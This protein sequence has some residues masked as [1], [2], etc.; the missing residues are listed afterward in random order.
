MNR[1]AF[2]ST[3]LAIKAI[4]DMTR[5][6]VNLHDE[7]NIPEGSVIFAVNH[8][9][10]IETIFLPLHL[11][12][13]TGVPVWSLADASLFKGFV[14]DFISEAGAVSTRDP[15]RD[16]LMVKSLL[17]GEANWVIFPEGRMVKTKKIFEDGEFVIDAE[18]G[19]HRPHTGA[20]TLALRTEFYRERLRMMREKQPE[21]Y[22][23]LLDLFGVDE[24]KPRLDRATS[25]VPV[26][27]TYYPLRARESIISRITG[28]LIDNPSSRTLEEVM[29]E[30]SM[31]LDGVDVDVR[32]GKPIKVRPYLKNPVVAW[33]IANPEPIDFDDPINS[34]AV[35]REASRTLMQEYMT[36]IYS[37]TMVNHDHIFS[38]LIMRHE[39]D[40]IDPMDLKTR[41]FVVSDWL[42]RQ[43]GIHIHTSLEDSQSHLLTDDRYEK[44]SNIMEVAEQ[45]G[46]IRRDE[47]GWIV[48]N[49]DLLCNGGEF[50]TLRIQNPLMVMSNEVE[51]L[52][53]LTAFLDQVARE[54]AAHIRRRI[55]GL[56][57]EKGI[58]DFKKD[59]EVY[60]IEGESKPPEIGAPCLLNGDERRIGVLLIHG[61]MAAPAEVRGLAD[62][63]QSQGYWVYTPR[64]RGHGTAPE[65]LAGRG[66]LDWVVSVEEGYALLR[67]M[68]DSLFIGGFSTGAG[69]ALDLVTRIDRARTVKGVFAV[70]PPMKLQ[71]YSSRFV[72]AVDTWNTVMKRLR[73]DRARKEFIE[74]KPENPHINY[75]RNSVAGIREI[76]RLMDQLAPKLEKIE[77]PALIVQSARDP[78]VSPKGSRKVF[79]S[80]AS[81]DKEYRLFNFS[82]HG[83]L[84]HEGSEK[85]YRA[86][87]EFLEDHL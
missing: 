33:D 51:P 32:F 17:T 61:Y 40:Y 75:T 41:A 28:S 79:E 57:L 70:A 27:I 38:R 53:G 20:A 8:F 21:E 35:L 15:D 19:K 76:D 26:N 65:D 84:L 60:S 6:R 87:S 72:P 37:M 43:I 10:R 77:I 81:E 54:P 14:G 5:T 45:K 52:T 12:K 16:K 69:L 50:H 47:E 68:C 1:F 30:G 3:G 2:L 56:L 34:R 11:Q 24:T 18:E 31:L 23:R 71:D 9:T 85:V 59:Y 86:V 82:R 44:F 25:I 80:I 7:E 64:L 22:R 62:H 48:R 36:A 83:I 74:N 63:L 49:P 55:F 13:L 39:S 29:T 73:I 46:V 66:Y 67:N 4:Y 42:R 78:V 58:N